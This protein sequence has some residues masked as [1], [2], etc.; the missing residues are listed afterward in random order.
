[1]IYVNRT[2]SLPFII[3]TLDANMYLKTHINEDGKT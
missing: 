3:I 1:M 2:V